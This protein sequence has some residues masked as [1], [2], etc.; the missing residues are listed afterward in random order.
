MDV[1]AV[2]HSYYAALP[3]VELQ[4]PTCRG[5]DIKK[6]SIPQLQQ[7]L[8]DRKF[9]SR[10][11][12]ETYLERIQGLNRHL[13]AVIEINPDALT[14]AE[15][16]DNEREDGK[17]RSPLHGIP[18][19]VKDNIATK[20]SMD[21]T[22]AIV[23]IGA[24]VP[25][26]AE[27]VS[28]LRDAGAVLL[29]HAN[30][31]EWA[32]MRSSYYSEGYSARGGQCR[33]PYNLAE[34][35]GGT[36]SGSAVAVATNMVSFSIGTET[37]GSVM[38]PADRN[39]VVGIKPTVGLTSTKGLIPESSS[40]DT[41][42]TFGKTVVDA[43]IGLDAITGGFKSVHTSGSYASFVVNKEALKTARFGL[44][45]KRVW[46]LAKENEPEQ[47]NALMTVIKLIREAGAE[48]VEWRELPSAEEIIPPSGWDCL[49]TNPNNIR[50]L[51]D[52]VA[53]NVRNSEM[54]GGQPC[55]HPAWPSGQDNFEQSLASKGILDDTYYN[56]LGYIRKKS[57][58]EGIDAALRMS[59]GSPLDGLLVPLQAD[60]GAA[61]QVAAKA[62]Y[63]MIAIPTNINELGVPFGLAIIQTAWREDLLIKYG[64]AIEDLVGGRSK[65]MFRNL[66]AS[67]Y[68]YVGVKPDY[69]C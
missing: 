63:P 65:P 3:V 41:V 66:K 10:D 69:A 13:K 60:G 46:E 52:I 22:A 29:G 56:A 6:L 18:F 49:R 62:G 15:Q 40:L 59:D 31:S 14:I 51:E 28:L 25:E 26:D 30:L 38:F 55:T 7:Y 67:N 42:G 17:L 8:I 43:A 50:N 57:R 34:N 33:N 4:M 64:S 53:W 35:P 54:E 24:T 48:V 12:V 16:L 11:L 39:A 45:W 9:S 27:I 2:N 58:E 61:C 68:M 37:D 1:A 47:Y 23:L 44:P 21:T 36:S 32:A 19:L 5:I 20:D